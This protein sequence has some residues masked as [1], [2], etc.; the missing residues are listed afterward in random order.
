MTNY[1]G[2]DVLKEKFTNNPFMIIPYIEAAGFG[3]KRVQADAMNI[4][5][6]NVRKVAKPSK[7]KDNLTFYRDRRDRRDS[8]VDA[9]NLTRDMITISKLLEGGSPV[10]ENDALFQVVNKIGGASATGTGSLIARNIMGA[11]DAFSS[12][13][14]TFGVE[15]KSFKNS[16]E[17]LSDEIESRTTREGKAPL[18]NSR[19]FQSLIEKR[20]ANSQATYKLDM[21]E[22]AEKPIL[23]ERTKAEKLARHRLG[24]RNIILFKK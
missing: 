21:K 4:I 22:A 17:G 11:F 23:E 10:S 7:H 20:L 15:F 16:L 12:A 18:V 8:Q 3:N 13:L 24:L 6:D 9:R 14:G 1:E 5:V 2:F 19:Q